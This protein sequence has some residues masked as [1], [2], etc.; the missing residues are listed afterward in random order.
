MNFD[1][2]KLKIVCVIGTRPEAIKMAPIIK[3]LENNI[4][5]E[6]IVVRT[7]QHKELLDDVLNIFQI[8]PLFDLDVMTNNQDLSELTSK[9][10][11]KFGF[12]MKK[13]KPGLIIAQG[14][15][16]SAMAAALV[17]FYQKIKFGHIE[18]GLRTGEMYNP[19]PE[20]VNRLIISKLASFHFTPT[21]LT[22]DNLIKENIPKDNIFICGNTVIDSLIKTLSIKYKAEIDIDKKFI[23]VT[24]HRRE[25]FDKLRSIFS[26]LKI[27][28]SKNSNINFIFLIHPNPN[29][30]NLAREYLG[31]IN[32]IILLTPQNYIS[33][34]NLMKK[35][36]F[37]VSDSG[38]I[39]EE[40]AALGKPLLILRSTTERK[41]VVN[42]KVAK[43][44]GVNTQNIINEIDRLI[45][46]SDHYANMSKKIYPYG[47]GKSSKIIVE[48]IKKKILKFKQ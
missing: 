40:A 28:A 6:V 13:I 35:S 39:Q 9:I 37:I 11:S 41:E 36:L 33:F 32:N 34:V 18:A 15:T 10:I 47:K 30:N 1:N 29:I 2:R 16:T 31:S 27:S 44:V 25:N 42:A 24:V 48:I 14:D 45:T 22:R 4:W 20:E 26:G 12:L 23:L 46:D 8:N 43:L 5:A 7:S 3:E 21:N 17:S 38:G 19:F